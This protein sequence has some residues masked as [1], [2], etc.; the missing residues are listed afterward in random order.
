MLWWKKLQMSVGGLEARLEAIKKLG[1]SNQPGAVDLLIE[2]LQDRDGQ[3]PM[4]AAQALGQLKN[5][6]AIP[7]LV[8]CLKDKEEYLRW[9]AAEALAKFG[10]LAVSPLVAAMND[11]DPNLHEVAARTLGK[12]GL[13]A[14]PP[15]AQS[16][17]HP[18]KRV[19]QAAAEAIGSIANERAAELL[20]PVLADQERTVREKAAQ[21]LVH[22][23]K[24]AVPRLLKAADHSDAEIRKWALYALEKIGREPMTETYIRP[25]GHGKW[26]DMTDVQSPAMAGLTAALNDPQRTTRLTAI[27]S[28][29]NI[30]DDRAVPGL[31]IALRDPER[32]LRDTAIHAL[33]KIGAAVV[34][35]LLEVLKDGPEDLREKAIAV[36]GYIGDQ[37]AMTP[38]LETLSHADAALRSAA[39][40]ALASFKD[41]RTVEPLI[42]ALQDTDPRVR[43][44]A[45]GSLCQVGGAQTQDV[46]MG[47][48]ADP[49]PPTRKRAIQ[50]LGNIGD[51]RIIEPMLK[52]FEQDQTGR[53]ETALAIAK[54][55]PARAAGLLMTLA[56][57]DPVDAEEAV[58]ILTDVM[59]AAGQ[60][61]D[62]VDLQA[63]VDLPRRIAES[64]ASTTPPPLVKSKADARP[65]ARMA[66][67]ELIRR[68]S[69]PSRQS[70][71]PIRSATDART[72]PRRASKA[73]DVFIMSTMHQIEPDRGRVVDVSTG[74]LGLSTKKSF[75]PGTNLSLR[76][77]SA[78]DESPWTI[79]EVRH[80][81]AQGESFRVGCRFV[82]SPHYGLMVLLG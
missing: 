79:V 62:A 57:T 70:E 5:S 15:L 74:G 64:N 37:R 41:P 44:N 16:L 47:L 23:G 1:E 10:S 18:Q 34:G 54:I 39:A 29:A 75:P 31:I 73:V 82:H 80:C 9:A 20:I 3:V 4:H 40:D 27:T 42:A 36:L 66:E 32:E 76:P 46:L 67:E 58:E 52:L 19:R 2:A 11:P 49:D 72:A 33:V 26:K 51:E 24:P 45:V 50:A 78:S 22:I 35:P 48:L 14:L 43:Y 71:G 53:L 65:L 69:L 68:G 55:K 81:R 7:A 8:T 59:E 13:A 63:I 21:A 6:R 12:I 56:A 30:G 61:L 17:R 38:L 60:E 25:V 28:L 77:T